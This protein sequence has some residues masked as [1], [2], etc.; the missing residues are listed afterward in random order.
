[1]RA[2]R[3]WRGLMIIGLPLC[4]FAARS[5]AEPSPAIE[6]LSN[7]AGM[8]APLRV[9]PKHPLTFHYRRIIYGYSSTCPSGPRLPASTL[10][11][12][13]AITP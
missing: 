12:S 4:F 7:E 6:P 9:D 1:M 3:H 5:H 10:S 8:R 13:Q 2:I 11:W